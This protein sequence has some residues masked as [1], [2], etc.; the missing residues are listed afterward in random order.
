MKL[1][2]NYPFGQEYKDQL[3]QVEFLTPE[4]AFANPQGVEGVIGQGAFLRQENLD[5][6][7]DLKWVQINSSGYD[8]LDLEYFRS[9]NLTL[10][11]GKSIYC[12]TVAEDV[13]TKMLMLARQSRTYFKFQEEKVWA[14][15]HYYDT[16]LSLYGKTVAILGVGAIGTEIAKRVKGFEMKV[17]GYSRSGRP[18]E[19]FDAVYSGEEG[20][21]TVLSQADFAVFLTPYSPET[22]HLINETTMSYMK[23]TAY[24]I[25]VSRGPVCDQEALAKCLA[26][27]VIAGAAI[28]VT[29]PEPLPQDSFLW[30]IPNLILTPHQASAGDI[31]GR[32]ADE[33]F[34]HNIKSFLEGGEFWNVV[35]Y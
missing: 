16:S 31:I 32:R 27:G 3:P 1:L 33:L 20:L 9:R 24:V 18:A 7:P 22:H 6:L 5:R 8:M 10:T 13:V 15:R 25:N 11:N 17:I 30:E 28:D 21:K 26:Q 14:S 12:V 29:D 19:G 34:F 4:E 35:H 23:P 2:L